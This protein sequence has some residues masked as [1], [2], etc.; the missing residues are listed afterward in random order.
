MA[1][2]QLPLSARLEGLF[3]ARAFQLA[4]ALAESEQVSALLAGQ[5]ALMCC[6][7]VLKAPGALVAA[8]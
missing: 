3:K 1:L 4:L 5:A 8:R 6:P 2:A 7:A